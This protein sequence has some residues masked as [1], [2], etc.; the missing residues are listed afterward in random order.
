MFSLHIFV[1]LPLGLALLTTLAVAEPS[2][3][4]TK[5]EAESDYETFQRL[6][7]QADPP[8]LHAA[9]H[10]FAPRFKHGMFREDKNAVEFIHRDD[11]SL[12][13]SII[14]LA[15]RQEIVNGTFTSTTS[16]TESPTPIDDSTTLQT[17]VTPAPI[18]R[19]SES[20]ASIPNTESTPAPDSTPPSITSTGTEPTPDA[21]STVRSLASSTESPSRSAGSVFTYT[22]SSG[23]IV[24]TTVSGEA[25]TIGTATPPSTIASD[26]DSTA[27]SGA[28]V[29]TRP[30]SRSS[31]IVRATT[32]PDGSKSTVTA[33]TVVPGEDDTPT[34]AGDAGAGSSTQTGTG[35][36]SVQTGVAGR[37]GSFAKEMLFAIGGVVGVAML[38]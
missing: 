26:S 32:L 33:V 19:T 12:A 4:K 8:S 35:A 24:I 25:T 20:E 36:P 15:K 28:S 7:Q 37:A 29:T 1:Y 18:D 38:M 27:S 30:G 3:H 21:T 16:P 34:P 22:D 14:K 11:A 13:T 23:I 2:N 9:L 10:D 31:V 17:S 6:L 5:N